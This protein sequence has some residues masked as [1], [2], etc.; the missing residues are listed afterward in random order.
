[1][2][3]RPMNPDPVAAAG[4]AAF[5][6]GDWR[7]A[8]ARFE[9]GVAAGQTDP[10][11]LAMLAA[12][13]FR[14]DDPVAAHAAADRALGMD[15]FNLRASLTKADLLSAQGAKREANAY[16]GAVIAIGGSASD[17]PDDLAQGVA[18]A[19]AVRER[20]AGDMLNLLESELAAAGYSAARSPARFTHALDILTG[21]RQPYFQQPRAFYYPELPNTQFYPREQF[22]WL[23]AVEAATGTMTAELSAVLQDDAG[24]AP[25]LQTQPG[26]PSRTDY[27]LVD[28]MDWSSCFLWKD[29]RETDNAARCPGTMTALSGAPL[30]R[31]PGR[32]P[33]IMF[34]Q[35]KAGAH[36]LPHVGFVNTRLICHLPLIVPP[37][38]EFRVGNEVRQWEVGK[39]WVFDDTIEH[40]ARNTGDRT[41]VV[42]IF[43][44]WRPEIDPEERRLI[45]TL[46]ETLDAYS[47]SPAVWE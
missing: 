39:A 12:A 17:L 31:I 21:R 1:M 44:I 9:Q 2:Q 40:E 15:Q 22:G 45:T 28:S 10:E 26:V 42:L 23:D 47:P 43:D 5:L 19:R 25:Y 33:Q 38:C 7:E 41:R 8:R 14:L 13:C 4:V 3:S 30:C 16:Y 36:I 34:S 32:S 11:A 35:L 27:P 37:G 6:A 29:G 46:L 18:R 24:F 20:L